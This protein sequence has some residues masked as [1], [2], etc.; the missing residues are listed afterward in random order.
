MRLEHILVFST[1]TFTAF[2]SSTLLVVYVEMIAY[3]N[4]PFFLFLMIINTITEKTAN[5]LGRTLQPLPVNMWPWPQK[6]WLPEAFTAPGH[7]GGTISGVYLG[8][9]RQLICKSPICMSNSKSFLVR[10]K[11]LHVV[12]CLTSRIAL[13]GYRPYAEPTQEN[14]TQGHCFHWAL[15]FIWSNMIHLVKCH[16]E[17]IYSDWNTGEALKQ[18]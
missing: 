5:G 15:S 10:K 2:S 14:P 12:F 17:Q 18:W 3:T 13:I 8:K 7:Y 9:H 4:L 6:C 16:S 1:T 11:F